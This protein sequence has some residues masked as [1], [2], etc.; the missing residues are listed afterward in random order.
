MHNLQKRLKYDLD[1]FK[2]GGACEMH[3]MRLEKA[4][5]N[6]VNMRTHKVH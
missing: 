5:T 2:I 6:S 1:V 4:L 3:G